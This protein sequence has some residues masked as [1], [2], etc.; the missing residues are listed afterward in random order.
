MKTKIEIFAQKKLGIE[1][2]K[3]QV[4][5]IAA[6]A[7][8]KIVQTAKKSGV[9]TARRVM[10]EYIKEGLKNDNNNSVQRPGDTQ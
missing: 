7:N 3:F 5:L 10:R 6:W 8:D 9:S 1:L 2:T 4:K